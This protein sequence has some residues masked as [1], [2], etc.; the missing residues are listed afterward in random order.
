MLIAIWWLNVCK[1]MYILGNVCKYMY[2]LGN[3]FKVFRV[4][5]I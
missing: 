1:Y 2:I 3:E 5:Y 4:Q